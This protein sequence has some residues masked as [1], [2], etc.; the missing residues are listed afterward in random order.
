MLTVRYA[1][2]HPEQISH[3][4]LISTQCAQP[5]PADFETRFAPR[6][7]ADFEGHLRALGRATASEPH[8]FKAVEDTVAYGLGTTPELVI[9]SL[10]GLGQEN[11]RDLL[12]RVCRE[13]EPGAA[14]G[15][16]RAQSGEIPCGRGLRA[17]ISR[18]T[19]TSV[20]PNRALEPAPTGKIEARPLFEILGVQPFPG[21]FRGC[22]REKWFLFGEDPAT[23]ERSHR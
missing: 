21:F 18:G 2:E 8:S 13:I 9:E 23:R 3:L 11:T 12:A 7:R 10:R 1:V 15:R 14:P 17:A 20:S 4:I 16:R 22:A 5:L 19:R 6:I